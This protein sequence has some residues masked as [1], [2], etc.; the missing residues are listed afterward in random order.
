[1]GACSIEIAKK[2]AVLIRVFMIPL[3]RAL[4]RFCPL[5][6]FLTLFALLFANPLRAQDHTVL[7]STSD[8]GVSKAITNWG[9][10]VTWPNPDNM[11][12]S[13][14]FMGTNEVDFGHLAFRVTQARPTGDLRP[15]TSA[16]YD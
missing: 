5:A 10:S 2:R 7:F 13:L 8:P 14:I 15:A 4:N 6:G 3:L 9:V 1:M 16:R 11:R 12:R